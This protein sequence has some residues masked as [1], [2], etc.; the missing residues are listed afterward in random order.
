MSEI[1]NETAKKFWAQA[2]SFL[3]NNKYEETITYATTALEIILKEATQGEINIHSHNSGLS[4]ITICSYL[5]IDI[6]KY[7]RYRKMVGY[8]QPKI[9]GQLPEKRSSSQEGIFNTNT[10]F[11]TNSGNFSRIDSSKFSKTDAEISLNYC[12]E[13]IIQIEEIWKRLSKPLNEK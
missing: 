1:Q 6:E 3:E 9:I 11:T 2:K 7:V 10:R 5:N 13:T 8:W 4:E 12:H